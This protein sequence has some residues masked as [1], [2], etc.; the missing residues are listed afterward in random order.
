MT[1][2]L[3]AGLHYDFASPRPRTLSERENRKSGGW[4]KDPTES[5]EWKIMGK[6]IKLKATEADAG[7][8]RRRI[9][10]SAHRRKL[11]PCVVPSSKV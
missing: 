8:G 4:G 11:Q 6:H 10:G 3:A 9:Q 5:S 7:K 2:A 1:V